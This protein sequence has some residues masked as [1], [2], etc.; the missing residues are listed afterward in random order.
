ML[1][2][3]TRNA[4]FRDT[5]NIDRGYK[6][7]HKV[8]GEEILDCRVYCTKNPGA[9]GYQ[10]QCAIW[11]HSPGWIENGTGFG[12]KTHGCGYSK[13]PAAIESALKDM[14]WDNNARGCMGG[15]YEE[16]K[17]LAEFLVGKDNFHFI[18]F[19]G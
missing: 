12:T 9:H 3:S 1:K 10:M 4:K 2:E 17:R 16:L 13:E 7:I 5:M 19:Y 6:A 15:G 18:S 8:T 11:A 14:G